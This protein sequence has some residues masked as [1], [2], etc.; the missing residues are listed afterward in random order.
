MLLSG[1]MWGTID[2]TYDET[3]I[4]EKKIRLF[5]VTAFTPFQISVINVDEYIQK[6]ADF[7]STE[8]IDILVNSCGLD[9]DPLDRRQK[10]LYLCRCLPW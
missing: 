1:G 6:R 9:P 10:L 3:E 5:K 2:L 4:H 7:T 8:W